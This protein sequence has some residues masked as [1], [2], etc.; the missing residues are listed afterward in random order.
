MSERVI[1]IA[2]PEDG[3]GRNAVA[4][5]VLSALTTVARTGVFRPIACRKSP[6]TKALVDASNAG[7]NIN[8]VRGV[9]PKY[10]REHP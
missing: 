1:Y 10:A 8:D 5:G 2:S 6:I 7:Q 3:N 4:Y 9:C